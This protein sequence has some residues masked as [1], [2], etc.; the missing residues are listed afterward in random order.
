[1]GVGAGLDRDAELLVEVEVEEQLELR[2]PRSLVPGLWQ[3]LRMSCPKDSAQCCG[4]DNDSNNKA[5]R[6]KNHTFGKPQTLPFHSVSSEPRHI[7]MVCTIVDYFFLALFPLT[8][9]KPSAFT[10]E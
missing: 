10:S 6:I 2:K 9:C 1:M 7:D 4:S 5:A 8:D 3:A